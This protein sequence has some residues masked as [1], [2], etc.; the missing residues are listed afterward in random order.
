MS[1]SYISTTLRAQREFFNAFVDNFLRVF[2]LFYALRWRGF[3]QWHPEKYQLFGPLSTLTNDSKW[4]IHSTLLLNLLLGQ[5]PSPQCRHHLWKPP[6]RRVCKWA[7]V[8]DFCTVTR[9]DRGRSVCICAGNL[10]LE[11]FPL[12]SG[13]N[14]INE[15]D[16]LS[17]NAVCYF[18]IAEECNKC[19]LKRE[20]ILPQELNH[21][22][23]LLW[24]YE[25]DI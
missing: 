24:P 4:R 20:L 6:D 5:P 23:D 14:C 9:L 18:M 3:H 19:S 15:R 22:F 1:D 13:N 12:V 11:I 10:S 17:V 25:Y 7:H 21:K 16:I 2:L 8:A